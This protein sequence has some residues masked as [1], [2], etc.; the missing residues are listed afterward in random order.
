MISK[1][2]PEGKQKD[3]LA[4]PAK[5]HIVVLGTAGSGKTTM[6]LFRALFLSN[7]PDKPNVL[8]VTFNGALVEYMTKIGDT[9]GPNI[10]IESFHKFARG[11]LNSIGKMPKRNGV[12]GP[13]EKVSCIK[14]AL[15]FVKSQHPEESTLKRALNIFVDEITFI[16][17]FGINSA[18]E[19]NEVERIGRASANIKREN[20]KWFFMVYEKYLQIRKELGRLYDWDD[21]ALYVYNNLL[22]DK[23]QRRY[24][25]IIVDEGQ[26]FSPIMIKALTKAIPDNGSF[27]FFG[28]VAQQI[29]GSRLSWRDSGINVAENGIWRFDKNYRNPTTIIKFAQDITKSKYWKQNSDMIEPSERIAKGP[30][31]ILLKFE[32]LSNEINWL[33]KQINLNSKTSSN[34]VVFRNR[35]ILETIRDKLQRKG[36][37]YTVIT[38]D[39]TGFANIKGIYLST[40]HAVKG[41][42]FDN[43]YIPFL[44]DNIFPDEDTIENSISKDTALSDELKLLYVATT[45]SKFGLFIS[46]HNEISRLFPIESINYDSVS[47]EDLD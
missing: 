11:Y 14:K 7:L 33:I 27:S 16:E 10:T 36:I 40:F 42:E 15:E 8:L 37:H 45:R 47:E 46:Y 38:K 26:D 25:H 9:L 13:D 4:L 43:V 21:I 22:L 32:N 1:I 29:Y 35:E 2:T 3:V 28:D 6:A 23:T 30:K 20:R 31:P 5:G 17:R 41:L 34:V 19:Y 18:E 24:Q 44:C 39:Q 12:L